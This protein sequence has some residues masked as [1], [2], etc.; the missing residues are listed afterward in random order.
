M[1]LLALLT[2]SD[3]AEIGKNNNF[4]PLISI[5]YG[6]IRNKY[7]IRYNCELAI[8]RGCDRE[9]VDYVLVNINIYL[10]GFFCEG[11]ND[12]YLHSLLSRF[13]G[14]INMFNSSYIAIY[15]HWKGGNITDSVHISNISFKECIGLQSRKSIRM[16]THKL[17]KNHR[18]KRSH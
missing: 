14:M 5:M 13:T 3:K 11:Y 9:E 7:L 8:D 15:F 16:H 4:K 1:A 6:R 2:Y 12:H 18:L 17:Y 10:R